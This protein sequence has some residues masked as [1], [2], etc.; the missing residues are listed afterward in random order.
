MH[1][2]RKH[3]F[4]FVTLARQ[5]QSEIIAMAYRLANQGSFDLVHVYANEEDIALPFAS[6]CSKPVVFTHHDPFNFLIR[7]RS[8][9]PKY[10]Q[11]NWL[12][13]SLSQRR[14]MPK[15]TNWVG[16]IYHGIERKRYKQN[17]EPKGNYVVYFGRIIET[18]G[19]HLAIKAVEAYNNKYGSKLRLK[20]AGKHYGDDYKDKY[21]HEN[22]QPKLQGNYV[23]YLG[24]IKD[25]AAKQ[26]LLGNAAAL[27]MPS[28]F[29][30]PFGLVMIEALACGTPII[31]LDSGAIP[32]VID[33]KVNGFLVKKVI[34]PAT[35][36]LDERATAIAIAGRLNNLSLIDRMDCRKSFEQKFTAEQMAQEHL[37]VYKKIATG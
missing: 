22:I 8:V 28:V 17:K 36:L 31:G 26:D 10:P 27:I 29:E 37:K 4:T 34:D 35:K 5:V 20:I 30:E 15:D 21:W 24:Y 6:L 13:L 33:S 14:T 12:S 7:Y 11:L 19:V 25:D 2:L 32:E 1:L 3:P 9:F 18:K 16:N 23:E